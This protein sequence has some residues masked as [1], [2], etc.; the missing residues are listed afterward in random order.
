MDLNSAVALITGASGGIGAALAEELVKAGARVVLLAR[1]AAKLAEVVDRIGSEHAV[2]VVG[3]VTEAGDLQR[4]VRVAIE[5]FGGLDILVNNAG[6]GL[7][8]R[9]ENLPADLLLETWKTN[10][11]GAVLAIQAA[12]PALRRSSRALIVNISSVTSI[13]ASPSLAGYAMTKAALN[14]L[15]ETLRK[16]LRQDGIRVLTIFPGYLGNE[17]AD[18]AY[19][20][21]DSPMVQRLRTTRPAR[22]SQDAARDIVRAILL[23]LDEWRYEE[24]LARSQ[25]ASSA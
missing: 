7:Y 4:A 23:D 18:H 2:A 15:S 6:I 3:S 10:L 8:G 13:T 11:L 16:E 1:R 12:L 20:A 19:Y 24:E 22:T 25:Q 5:R 17:F 9:V 14:L 21:D